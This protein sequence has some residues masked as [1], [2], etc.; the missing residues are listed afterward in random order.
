LSKLFKHENV[1]HAGIVGPNIPIGAVQK[2]KGFASKSKKNQPEEL[3]ENGIPIEKEKQPGDGKHV[4]QTGQ[5]VK[6][7][8]LLQKRN[9]KEDDDEEELAP[10]T[11]PG[12]KKESNQKP[13]TK[14]V[15]GK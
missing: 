14:A 1:N 7:K 8:S 2:K 11:K 12:Q 13:V 9:K 3:D 5:K 15:P 4:D 6:Y 10:P